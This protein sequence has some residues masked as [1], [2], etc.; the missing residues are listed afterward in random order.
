MI[1]FINV[2]ITNQRMVGLPKLSD[3]RGH[4]KLDIFRYML[5]S[6]SMI[7]W[8]SVFI[9]YSLDDEFKSQQPFIDNEIKD[10]FQ[11]TNLKINHFR[12]DDLE[13]WEGALKIIN[14]QND[15]WI[16][17]SC[18]DDHIFIDS[19]LIALNKILTS[20]EK[21]SKNYKYISILPSH[22]QEY[23]AQQERN[24]VMSLTK[25]K[26][27]DNF[28][29]GEIIAKYDGFDIS[30]FRTAGAIQILNKNLINYW[31]SDKE[32]LPKDLRRTDNI[33]NFPNNQ[34]TI[35]PHRE[36]CRHFDAYTHSN[37]SLQVVPVMFIPSGFFSHQIK[38]CYG[39]NS[40]QSGFTWLHPTKKMYS[41]ECTARDRIS[42]KKVDMNIDLEDLPLFWRERII[43]IEFQKVDEK[44]IRKGY[45]LQKLKELCADP[46]LGYLPFRAIISKKD[47]VFRSRYPDISDKELK[48]A[49]FIA[50]NFWDYIVRA[51]Y[52]IH[53]LYYSDVLILKI[54]GNFY[55]YL[56]CIRF[57][58]DASFYKKIF[59]KRVM[60]CMLFSSPRLLIEFIKTRKPRY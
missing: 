18:N 43:S 45:V 14:L 10:L 28:G 25:S 5:A 36:L 23:M 35:I 22:W 4:S 11:G 52:F 13:G 41:K 19:N 32:S 33:I 7:N 9:F 3:S 17:F 51:H 30:T 57:I 21:L 39:F 46:R 37:L 12:I 48:D 54:L 16:W 60:L 8:S 38:I 6:Y 50:F 58:F 59:N 47:D 26:L 2:F 20:A 29:S 27:I 55:F 24:K 34:I 31:F 40:R 56:S 42:N 49:A 1:L 15:E 53:F 44:I